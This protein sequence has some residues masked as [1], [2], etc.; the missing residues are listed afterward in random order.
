MMRRHL[1]SALALGA[2][3]VT[4]AGTLSLAAAQALPLQSQILRHPQIGEVEVSVPKGYRL[5]LINAGLHRPRMIAFAPNGDMFIGSALAVYLLRPPYDQAME[6]IFL[7]S[8]PHSVAIRDDEMFIAT[9]AALYKVDYSPSNTRIFLNQ[10]ERVAPLPGGFGHSSRTVGIG[11][12]RRIYVSI[13]ISGNCSHEM[14]AAQYPFKDRRG[15]LLALDESTAPPRLVP[16]ASGLRNPVGFDW[17][18]VTGTMYA[19]NNGPDHLGFDQP[20]EYFAQVEAGSFH[21][22]PWYQFNGERIVADPCIDA[23]A[24]YSADRVP[25]PAATFAPRSAPLGMAFVPSTAS[26]ERFRDNAIVAIHGSWGTAPSGGFTGDQASRRPPAVKMVRFD[27]GQAI[28]VVSVIEG[29]QR[30]DGA[31]WAR[32]AGIGATPEGTIFITSDGGQFHGLM[33]LERIGP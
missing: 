2:A 12:D 33:R 7:D 17:H 24:P 32:P 8:Y 14:I 29:F 13:G 28:D 3:L 18:P 27:A 20:P 9:T 19:S 16:F 23:P 4:A 1:Q 22:M 30:D 26:D 15:G 25:L 6:Y 21:G 31:R 10:L 5:E 11:P